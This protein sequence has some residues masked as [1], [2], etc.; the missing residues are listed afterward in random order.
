MLGELFHHL[1]ILQGLWGDL[2]TGNVQLVIEGKFFS[3]LPAKAF[4]H[5]VCYLN[6]NV[7]SWLW[8]LH[9]SI[10]EVLFVFEGT[11]NIFFWQSPES[12]SKF[13]NRCC[14]YKK[15][16]QKCYETCLQRNSFDRLHVLG[17]VK[18][19][20]DKD[21]IHIG[22]WSSFWPVAIWITFPSHPI[23]KWFCSCHQK[24]ENPYPISQTPPL[25][26]FPFP[27]WTPLDPGILYFLFVCKQWVAAV[28]FNK[29]ETM[30]M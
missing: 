9:K 1:G 13:S 19:Y 11:K 21:C 24:E 26:T 6:L 16:I 25:S 23:M 22:K 14:L 29:N 27:R 30:L 5:K 18:E 8:P 2:K 15:N 20:C 3:H 17:L 12:Q 10:N 7:L 4:I 28:C